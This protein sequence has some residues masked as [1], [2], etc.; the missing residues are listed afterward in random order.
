M[1]P[2]NSPGL[3]SL[4]IYFPFS[5]RQNSMCVL[6]LSKVSHAGFQIHSC[7]LVAFTINVLWSCSVPR[8]YLSTSLNAGISKLF[9]SFIPKM[10]SLFAVYRFLELK[11]VYTP[12][13]QLLLSINCSRHQTENSPASPLLATCQCYQYGANNCFHLFPTVIFIANCL[14]CSAYKLSKNW[15]F[16][17]ALV[18]PRSL[19][20]SSFISSQ[21]FQNENCTY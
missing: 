4:Y 5:S 3:R 17:R 13:V 12:H 20:V 14:K 15:T 2:I 19:K 7:S 16:Q 18:R 11:L 9:L 8:G 10:V 1:I 6:Q 21:L